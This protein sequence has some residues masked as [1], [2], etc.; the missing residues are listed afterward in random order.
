MNSALSESASTTRTPPSNRLVLVRHGET[1]WSNL[2]KHT[3]VTDLPLTSVGEQQAR[4][5]GAVLAGRPFGSL[6][7]LL[8][9]NIGTTSDVDP[10]P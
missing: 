8:R 4:N 3:S 10:S 6:L 9:E 1:N 2:G 5:V 7:A